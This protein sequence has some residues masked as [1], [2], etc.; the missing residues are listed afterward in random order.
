MAASGESVICEVLG[1]SMDRKYNRILCQMSNMNIV[2]LDLL[3][4]MTG[5]SFC[6]F[7]LGS[8][9]VGSKLGWSSHRIGFGSVTGH[10]GK[11][12]GVPKK[13]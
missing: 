5:F 9:W 8:K 12:L 4:Q 3:V 6:G 1:P 2:L 10:L 7:D 13:D 11:I